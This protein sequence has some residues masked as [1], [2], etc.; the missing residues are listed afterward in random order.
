MRHYFLLGNKAR[1]RCKTLQYAAASNLGGPQKAAAYRPP[2]W[3]A[4]D[5]DPHVWRV[6]RLLADNTKTL[7][8][9]SSDR[10]EINQNSLLSSIDFHSDPS[11]P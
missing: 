9:A 3:P 8:D 6:S 11:A 1:G 4:V 10:L 7:P 5:L 2:F